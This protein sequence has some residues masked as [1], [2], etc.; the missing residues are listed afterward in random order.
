[1]ERTRRRGWRGKA[2]KGGGRRGI[3]L[4]LSVFTDIMSPCCDV[5]YHWGL[6]SDWR[7]S[8]PPLLPP[9]ILR[10]SQNA[11]RIVT[12]DPTSTS[13]CVFGR[14]V[15]YLIYLPI[16][17]F[18]FSHPKPFDMSRHILMMIS[19]IRFDINATLPNSVYVT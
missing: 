4:A 16:S 18:L 3:V 5:T 19:S 17:L 15:R 9:R 1:M 8:P 11:F 2:W 13:K 6:P 7:P 12:A 10:P 14:R